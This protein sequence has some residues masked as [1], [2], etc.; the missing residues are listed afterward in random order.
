M[1]FRRFS[2]RSILFSLGLLIAQA[3]TP[4]YAAVVHVYVSGIHRFFETQERHTDNLMQTSGVVGTTV[5]VRG[6]GKNFARKNLCSG[7][8]AD[9][10][11]GCSDGGGE[12]PAPVDPTARFDRPVPIGVP[13]YDTLEIRDNINKLTVSNTQPQ[14]TDY[15][16]VSVS[17]IY[18][19]KSAY[20]SNDEI[21]KG[22]W[23]I[24]IA[25]LT[26]RDKA[27]KF[28]EYAKTKGIDA[29]QAHVTVKGKNYW[30]VSVKGF[31]TLDE[32]ES[33]AILVKDRLGLKEVWVSKESGQSS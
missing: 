14:A 2:T 33:Y 1:S 28:I 25:S 22:S 23:C 6:D 20:K 4:T 30:R 7:P 13:A 9:R 5:G 8:P 11:D 26:N 16:S 29:K 10:P 3:F 19:P 18:K 31:L 27:N 21:D 17:G 24:N 15:S 12:D 32:A